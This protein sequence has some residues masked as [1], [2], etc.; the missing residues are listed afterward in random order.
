MNFF[1]FFLPLSKNGRVEIHHRP[2]GGGS[3]E[4]RSTCSLASI[5]RLSNDDRQQTS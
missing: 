1:T 2:V 4:N 5:G 3:A